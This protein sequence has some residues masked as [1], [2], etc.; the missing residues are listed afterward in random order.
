MHCLQ[1]RQ[2]LLNTESAESAAALEWGEM[3]SHSGG[4]LRGWQ[5][6]FSPTT[7]ARAGADWAQSV[8]PRF[9]LALLCR[10]ALT[11]INPRNQQYATQWDN[12]GP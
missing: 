4:L 7:L 2:E 6:E 3:Q 9:Y 5:V 11:L 8:W 1:S 12:R 10:P